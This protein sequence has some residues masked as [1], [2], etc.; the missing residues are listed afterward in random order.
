MAG[1]AADAIRSAGLMSGEN[2]QRNERVLFSTGTAREPDES[3]RF[4]SNQLNAHE[5]RTTKTKCTYIR[6]SIS[7]R[8][9]SRR[10]YHVRLTSIADR[11]VGRKK[12]SSGFIQFNTRSLFSNN[13]PAPFITVSRRSTCSKHRNIPASIVS[14]PCATTTCTRADRHRFRTP[15]RTVH[16]QDC[17]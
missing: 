8:S 17:T 12:A 3:D 6:W 14:S 10:S 7:N 13:T 15:R 9:R 11:T 1:T 5:R 2:S 4:F 16:W